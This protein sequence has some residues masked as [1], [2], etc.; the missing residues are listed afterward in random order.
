[1]GDS[2]D[3]TP[4]VA[5]D[6]HAGPSTMPTV[7]G[8]NLAGAIAATEHLLSL[9][10]RR[11]GF[12]AGRPD[13]ESARQREQGYRQALEAAGLSV[14]PELIRVGG[15][16]LELSEE[17]A[18]ELLSVADRPTAIFAAN[19]LSAIQTLHVASGLGLSV[20]GDLSVVGFDNIPE[21]AV[22]APPLTT[23]DQ[24]IQEMGRRAVEMLLELIEG[25]APDEPR[26]VTLPTRLVVRQSTGPPP[27]S[28]PEG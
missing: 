3:S 27:G 10:H 6:P 28:Q 1:V 4:I 2:G 19:D 17:P 8:D 12:L 7:H 26:Q 15:Y 22:I 24:S 20:P 9:G 14:D 5:V 16:E 23:I 18:R 13:L 21:S 25:T 11:I